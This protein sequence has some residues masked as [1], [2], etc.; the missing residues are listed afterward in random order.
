MTSD[1]V[2][3]IEI[4]V[5]F[6]PIVFGLVK[7]YLGQKDLMKELMDTHT[8]LKKELTDTHT[9]LKTVNA[10]IKKLLKNA[11]KRKQK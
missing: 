4:I 9:E 2:L 8:E 1:I 3:I 11:K 10:S 6:G 5:L 7:M